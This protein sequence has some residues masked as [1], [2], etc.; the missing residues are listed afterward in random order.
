MANN[1]PLIIITGGTRGLGLATAEYLSK[2]NWNLI[3]IDI[4]KEASKVYKESKNIAEVS[5]KLKNK[6]IVDFF[7][8][9]LSIEKNVKNIFKK[10]KKKYNKIDG[11]VTFAGGDIKGSDKKAGGGKANNNNLFINNKEFK[12]ICNRNFY[13]TY[14]TVKNCIPLMKKYNSGKI[15]T[16]SSILATFGNDSEFAYSSSKSNIIHLTRAAAA[17]CRKWNIN[18]NCIAPSGVKTGR[19]MSTMKK[20][21]KHDL[22][23][24]NNKKKL[25][26]FAEK[27]DIAKVVYFLLSDLSSFVS[28]QVIKLDGGEIL[29]AV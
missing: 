21:S 7:F 9:D 25:L 12:E 20:R 11:L 26:S 16:I 8:G 4:S 22:A 3:I 18:V 14:F 10:I 6:N 29:S 23:R 28:G 5:K 17:H 24:M 27:E 13:S 2:L 1:K 19:F 15:V